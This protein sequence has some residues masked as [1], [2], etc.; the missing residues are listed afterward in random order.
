MLFVIQHLLAGAFCSMLL[1]AGGCMFSSNSVQGSGVAKAETRDV[2]AFTAIDSTGSAQITVVIGDKQSLTIQA[3]DNILPLIDTKVNGEKLVISSSASYSARTPVKITITVAAL[4]EVRIGGSGNID[5]AGIVAKRFEA[6]ISGSG[7]INVAGQATTL[8][9]SISGSGSIDAT[10][11]PVDDADV[12][13]TG[14]GNVQINAT[15]SLNVQVTGSG[16][17]RYAG[18]PSE[19][20][21]QVTGSGRVTK[22]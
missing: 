8:K 21:K 18:N 1:S 10:K 2:P 16:D 5:A 3:D 17:V 12:R 13:V 14:S 6:H 4:N 22:M 19:V 7:D 11:L 20:K 9:A 15:K